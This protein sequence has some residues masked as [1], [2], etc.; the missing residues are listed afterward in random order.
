MNNKKVTVVFTSC[1]RFDLLGKTIESFLKYNTYPIEK[2]FIIDNSTMFE[3][4]DNLINMFP[5]N[6][7]IEIIM[8]ETNIGQVSSID[9]VYKQIN[10]EY[11][12]HCEDDWEFFDQGFIELS[13][14]VLEERKDV[15]NINIRVRFDGERG[16]MHPITGNFKTKNNIIYHEYQINYLD[17]WHG[18]SWNPGLRR[19]SDYTKIKPYKQYG[20]EQGVN[21]IMFELGYKAACLEKPYC[22]HIGINSITFKS[23]M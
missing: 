13:L 18:F 22:K 3:A 9:K 16:S 14:D 2:Y 21:K 19:L 20:N 1:G 10:T 6:E 4:Y 23:N 15:S 12:F 17:E 5:N 11:I 8:N 7:N